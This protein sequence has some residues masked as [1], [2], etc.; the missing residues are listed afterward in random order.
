MRSRQRRM[1][2]GED[3]ERQRRT[4]RGKEEGQ[5][6]MRSNHG[7][8]D[9]GQRGQQ[10]RYLGCLTKQQLII[11]CLTVG[12]VIL[13]TVITVTAVLLTKES[14]SPV[15][16][17]G[18]DMLDYLVQSGNISEPDGL[19]A[20]WFHRA[21]KKEEMNK[22]L[23]SDAMILEADV[24]VKGLGTPSEEPIP[25][26]AHPPDIFSDNTLDQWLDAVL[27]SKK[28]IKLDFKSLKS[29]GLSLDLLRQ[30][31]SDRGINQP[32]WLNADILRGPNVPGFLPPVNGTVFLQLIQ[33]K[34]P[35]VTLSPGW[36]VAYGP[37]LF[38]ESY[39]R[40]MVEEMYS[41]IKDVPQRVTFPVHAL[42]VRDGWQHLSWLL[43]Q[44]PRFSLT[45]WQGSNHPNISDLLF[46]RDNTHHTRVYYDIYEP[47]L[48][49]FKEAAGLQGRVRT[50]YP[51]GDLMDFLCPNHNSDTSFL[52]TAVT[53]R[54][55]L[56][57]HWFTVTDRA[58]LL[59]QLTDGAGERGGMLVVRMFSDITRP[60]VILVEGSGKSLQPLTLQDVLQLLEQSADARWG[61]YLRVHT[62][63]LLEASLTVLSSAYSR[64]TLYRPVWIDVDSLQ[65]SE[66]VSTVERLFPYV[67]I[68]LT[69][70]SWPPYVPASVAGLSQR[71][72][73]H[74]ITA[75]LPEGDRGLHSVPALMDRYDLIV[76]EDTESGAETLDVLKGLKSRRTGRA[77]TNLYVI[78]KQS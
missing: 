69:Q 49:Q 28:G 1:R 50:F 52:S 77:N 35:H 47:T 75:S 70:H 42:L 24:T 37:P 38:T 73:L 76:E 10:E 26:M 68:V 61:L 23:A 59:A 17:T 4:D 13:L 34:F 14:G 60:G 6:K 54:S 7:G 16:S 71:V 78:S 5:N 48:S 41:L 25:I 8:V 72:A 29:V 51:G 19:L 21:N 3:S 58:S 74:L 30:K 62:Q 43:N 67:T 20:T 45:L 15:P 39:N 12:L 64:G 46:V 57:V 44:S 22:A 18:A 11:I 56:N 9:S 31:N 63:Q 27:P 40:S 2:Q 32:V 33:E 53:Q 65:S 55:S 66:F 36:K